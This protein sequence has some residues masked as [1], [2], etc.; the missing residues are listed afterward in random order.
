[1]IAIRSDT[2][3]YIAPGV[4]DMRKA[5]N[6]L[7]VLVSQVYELDPFSGAIFVF[8]NR[9]RSNL[10]IIYWERNGFWLLQK[11]LEKGKFHWPE[12]EGEVSA[13]TLRELSW[14]LDG[15]NPKTVKGHPELAYSTIF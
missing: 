2:K 4:T 1:M 8:C 9:T 3:V 15:L 11:R 5:I 6:G 13:I 7:S 12:T 14:L 10:K